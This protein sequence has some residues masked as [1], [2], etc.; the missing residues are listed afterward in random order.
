L[1][2]LKTGD[3]IIV[4]GLQK[5]REGTLVTPITAPEVAMPKPAETAP[6]VS[7]HKE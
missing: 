5:V 4:E 1:E 6:E 2:G 7:Q 3:R